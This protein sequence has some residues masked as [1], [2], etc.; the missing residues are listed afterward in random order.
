MQ[1]QLRTN[2]PDNTCR[3]S[4]NTPNNLLTDPVI[5]VQLDD[6]CSYH[7]SLPQVLHYLFNDRI[8]SF[9]RLRPHQ[10]PAWHAFLVQL[11]A[12]ALLRS[13]SIPK[14]SIC[15]DGVAADSPAPE[16][17]T[18]DSPADNSAAHGE[19]VW[20]VAVGVASADDWQANLRR[21]TT[22]W[23][24]DEP[25]QLVARFDAPAFLQ[26]PATDGVAAYR[27]HLPTPDSL[28]ILVSAKNHDIKATQIHHAVAEDWVFALV[29]LQTQEGVM[30]AG[31]YG[32]ARMNGG[33]GSR[34]Y[35]FWAPAQSRPGGAFKRD[36]LR[37]LSS[38]QVPDSKAA[39]V[40]DDDRNEQPGL[41][42]LLPWPGDTQLDLAE[43]HPLFIE[44]CR[45]I[46]L[47]NRRNFGNGGWQAIQANTRLA[48]I[49]A[50]GCFGVVGDPWMPVEQGTPDKAL[51]ISDTGF[52]YQ[53]VVQVLFGSERRDYLLPRLA[54]PDAEEAGQPMQV[55]LTGLCRGQGKTHGFHS[56]TIQLP[57]FAVAAMLQ[58][59]QWLKHLSRTQLQMALNVQGR[60]L[61]PALISLFQKA[62]AEPIWQKTSSE[63]LVAMYLKQMD[64]EIEQIFFPHLWHSLAH[65]L[66][67]AGPAASG[68]EQDAAAA[69]DFYEKSSEPMLRAW[70]TQLED[71]A[72]ACLQRAMESTPWSE[73]R[74][75]MVRA[76]ALNILHGAIYKNFHQHTAT[77]VVAQE[78]NDEQQLSAG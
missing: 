33:Y 78:G 58:R 39:G 46:R 16:S 20:A 2:K 52:S 27:R 74:Q 51:T 57:D 70:L 67:C 60:C 63:R 59:S 5:S 37:L 28:D 48:R 23:P 56:R 24:Q 41:L 11:A 15:R 32:V 50:Q 35:V 62:P 13:D 9:P 69:A 72:A 3:D 53:R 65:C 22:A 77:P 4:E 71:M 68:P 38:A 49:D 17:P 43:L 44:I 47:I 34:S 1:N 29:S 25:W 6:G 31:N 10:A 61:R 19:P 54:Q 42:W 18:P 55:T 40:L 26:A 14:D 21:L 73:R 12:L 76:A 64:S 7:C 30:G 45:R 36:L 8:V 66:R 75:I